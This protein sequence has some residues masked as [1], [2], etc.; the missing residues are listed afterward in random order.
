MSSAGVALACAA[1]A[2]NVSPMDA[3]K[4]AAVSWS[5]GLA[6]SM[7][8]TPPRPAG[9]EATSAIASDIVL[10]RTTVPGA[11]FGHDFATW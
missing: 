6:L 7:L 3:K 5:L 9:V 10:L 1:G 2:P 11:C 4:D 8:M